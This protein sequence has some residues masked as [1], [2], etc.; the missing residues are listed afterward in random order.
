MIDYTKFPELNGVYLEDSYVLAI[1]ERPG[2]LTFMLEAVLTPEHPYYRPPRP[3]Q[4]YCYAKATLTFHDVSA[5][6][7]IKQSP[8]RYVDASG[9]EDLGNID[10]LVAERGV[11]RVDGDWGEVRIFT[12][13]RPRLEYVS[14]S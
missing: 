13:S 4:Q 1:I 12:S 9:E 11:Y 6:E 7:W 14:P 5:V 10:S 8:H 2:V 3:G